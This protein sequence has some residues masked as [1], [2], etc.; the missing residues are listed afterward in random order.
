[1]D[2]SIGQHANI[3]INLQ[4]KNPE[5]IHKVNYVSFVYTLQGLPSKNQ[6]IKI[7]RYKLHLIH[8]LLLYIYCGNTIYT[9]GQL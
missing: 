1:M 8:F 2:A 3:I 7:S 4:K 6:Y 9:S 5:I